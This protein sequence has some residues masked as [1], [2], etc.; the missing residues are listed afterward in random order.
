MIYMISMNFEPAENV[1]FKPRAIASRASSLVI[2]AVCRRVGGGF[3]VLENT[4]LNDW[5]V[6][7]P[8][9]KIF[10]FFSLN[11]PD[12]VGKPGMSDL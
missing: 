3:F 7:A 12:S 1:K 4:N 10:F 9:D 8:V 2:F 6:L 11:L 5:T